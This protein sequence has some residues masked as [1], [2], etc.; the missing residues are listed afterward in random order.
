MVS[1]SKRRAKKPST[2]QL[3]SQV[4]RNLE[5][6]NFKQALKDARVGYRQT[7]SAENRR[8]FEFALIA[9]M[10]DL[11]RQ[12]NHEACRGVAETLLD[13]GAN[14]PAVQAALPDLLLWLGLLDRLPANLLPASDEDRAQWDLKT[15]DQ[16]VLR[17]QSA[18][19]SAS[20]IPNG[21][22]RVRR[23]LKALERG[24]TSDVQLHLNDISRNSPFADWKFFVRGLAAYYQQD[25]EK[26]QANWSRL[27]PDRV[28]ATIARPLQ[29]VAGTEPLDPSDS[30]LQ[31]K[32]EKLERGVSE[33]C[34]LTQLRQ[35]QRHVAEEDWRPAF[36][37]LPGIRKTLCKLDQG[38]YTR[39]VEWLCVQVVREGWIPGLDRLIG[40]VD[41]LPLDPNW[42]RAR[43]LVRD[44]SSDSYPDDSI[45]FWRKYII[46]LDSVD[47]NHEQRGMARALV[48]L[49]L[50]RK[51]ARK[52]SAM[53][54]CGCGASHDD[55]EAESMQQAAACLEHCFELTPTDARAYGALADLYA[56]ADEPDQV[57]ETYRRAVQQIPD[58]LDG[59]LGLARHYLERDEPLEAYEF[60]LQAK[61]TKPL[62]PQMT[63]VVWSTHLAV[64]RY[65]ACRGQFDEARGRF[66]MA[67]A[68]M[69]QRSGDYG[70]LGRRAVVEIKAGCQDAARRWIENALETLEEPAS[71][72]LLILIESECYGLAKEERW[73]Y[74]KR[75][76]EALRRRCRGATAGMMCKLLIEYVRSR[77]FHRPHVDKTKQL[78]AYVRRCSRV[79]WCEQDLR[80]VCDFLMEVGE[81]VLLRKFVRKGI[82]KFPKA[83]YF[84]ALNGD[85]EIR[86]GP[87]R[88]KEKAARLS[89]ETALKLGQDSGDARVQELLKNSRR[90]LILLDQASD[91]PMDE[92]WHDDDDELDPEMQFD[93]IPPEAL[94]SVFETLSGRMGVELDEFL[95]DANE[96][97][98]PIPDEI[99]SQRKRT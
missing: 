35:L 28:A 45:P 40:V 1:K 3:L 7:A 63:A 4:Q 26:M 98:I 67:V 65:Y 43:A 25:T 60:A 87:F 66:E 68:L 30:S 19:S 54:N 37:A 16:S 73:L 39:L 93:G 34:I 85:L 27:A 21:A 71:L 69:P 80:D 51:Y 90:Q 10:Q 78:V 64:A 57:A 99:A 55:E 70:L 9:R 72:W 2:A 86:R 14:E 5:K 18:S 79:K 76:T 74:E 91:H 22:Q 29:V 82:K 24:D 96:R 89:L 12:G 75:W 46:D 97:G 42:N 33:Q 38:L 53:R 15:A 61:R 58:H 47:L 59:L 44:L 23:A 11:Q 49:N 94:L 36:R 77:Q 81:L 50:G 56:A 41:P 95:A 88:C 8:Y 62:D 52:A 17:P 84:H 92:P 31:S 6:G 13:L 48:W 32:L 83:A 20:G